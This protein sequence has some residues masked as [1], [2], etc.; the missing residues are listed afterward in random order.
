MR[1]L[2]VAA[3]ALFSVVVVVGIAF[4]ATIFVHQRTGKG[5]Q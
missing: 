5:P 4:I 3:K 1:R 2:K